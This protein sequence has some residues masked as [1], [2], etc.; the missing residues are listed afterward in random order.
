MLIRK[1][2]ITSSIR[3]VLRIFPA[4]YSAWQVVWLEFDDEFADVFAA[5]EHVDGFGGFFE[6]FDDGLAVFEL[7]GHFPHAEFL[8]GVHK[9]WNVIHDEEAFDAEA[10]DD[11][12]AEAGEAGIVLSV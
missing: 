10:L 2:Q 9:L 11:D 3:F 6:A 1:T 7:A 12:L 8:P 4:N 5:E